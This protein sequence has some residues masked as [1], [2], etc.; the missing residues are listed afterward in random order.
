MKTT[1][2]KIRT[3]I[4]PS[5]TGYLHIGTA[6]TALINYIFAKQHKG[7][8]VLRIED[9]DILRSES[10]FEDDIVEG[11]EWLGVHW[12]EGVKVGGDNAPYRQSERTETYKK[13]I[14]ELLEQGRAYHCFCSEEELEAHRQSMLSEGKPA[15]YSGRCA[16]L[17]QKEAKEKMEKGEKSIIRFRS[18]S[19]KIKF[20]DVIKGGVEF[21]TDL[22]G[23]IAI[24]KDE[25]TPLYNFAVVVDDH[26]MNITHVIRGED[27]VS[28]TPKQIVMQEA[29]GFKRPIYA[30]LSLVLGSDKRK[31]SKREGA[32]SLVE[33]K[34]DGYL[35]EALLNFLILLGWSPGDDREVFSIDE[36]IKEFKL[37]K[38]QKSGA[39]FNIKKLDWFNA[40]YIKRKNIKELAEL[41]LPYLLEADLIQEVEGGKFL[42]KSASEKV[43][44]EWIEKV[45]F[46]EKERIKKLSEISYAVSFFFTDKVSMANSDILIWKKSSKEEVL[47]AL[48]KVLMKL[49]SV[50]EGEFNEVNLKDALAGLAEEYGNG[51]IF[52]PLRVALSGREASPGPLEM[53]DVL[54]R[55][56]TL[57]RIKDAISLLSEK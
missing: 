44:M 38:F 35:P 11:L 14:K 52:W 40:Y 13:Y 45:V 8:F 15:V 48:N 30:H 2:Q 19:K 39:I 7:D 37:E 25:N 51:T 23:D 57:S 46:L 18:P 34:K 5:P 42:I 28:N 53:A 24:A 26:E 55:E 6:R 12:D 50:R 4:A 16:G 17:G 49:D 9:T 3:R 10:R 54:G 31:L 20:E 41:C 22:I 27:H 36:L 56:K 29:L 32:V 33:Y 1:L 21:E 43:G 47:E